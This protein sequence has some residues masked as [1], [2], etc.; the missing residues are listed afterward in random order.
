MFTLIVD[1]FGIHYEGKQHAHHLI[2]ALKQ[3]YKAVTT[4][5]D[6]T[7]FC[8]ITLNW[9]YQARFLSMPGY[10]VKALQEFQ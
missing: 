10:V 5:W 6:G 8:G 3:D 2:A 7:L 4:D 9:D 1:D